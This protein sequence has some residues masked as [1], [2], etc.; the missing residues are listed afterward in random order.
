MNRMCANNN[1]YIYVA[2][3]S[4]NRVILSGDLYCCLLPQCEV[5]RTC[6]S[7]VPIATKWCCDQDVKATVGG[8][9][10]KEQVI[11]AIHCKKGMLLQCL[12]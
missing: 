9:F 3:T 1:T 5:L 11:G 8:T 4:N 2:Q 12:R 7:G 10:T 6:C